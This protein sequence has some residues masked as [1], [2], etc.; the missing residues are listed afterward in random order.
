MP[1]SSQE[2]LELGP[3]GKYKQANIVQEE[4]T[5]DGVTLFYDGIFLKAKGNCLYLPFILHGQRVTIRECPPWPGT[6]YHDVNSNKVLIFNG[7]KWITLC[8]NE[9]V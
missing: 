6:I 9:T 7:D 8:S 4:I 5:E 2:A 1:N 3:L